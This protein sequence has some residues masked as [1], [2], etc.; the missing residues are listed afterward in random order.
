MMAREKTIKVPFRDELGCK[1]VFCAR[2]AHDP[3]R[4]ELWSYQAGRDSS[5]IRASKQTLA[6][7]AKLGRGLV[8]ISKP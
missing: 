4:I 1:W 2:R 3:E 8:E 5:H 7:A 6:Q